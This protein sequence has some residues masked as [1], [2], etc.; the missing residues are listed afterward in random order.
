MTDETA[1][2]LDDL[3]R[4]AGGLRQAVA[5]CCHMVRTKT[6]LAGIEMRNSKCVTVNW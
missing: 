5:K 3:A 4:Y 1:A 2:V 6:V